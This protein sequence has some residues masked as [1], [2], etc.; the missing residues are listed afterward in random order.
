MVIL[1]VLV[2]IEISKKSGIFAIVDDAPCWIVLQ[3]VNHEKARSRRLDGLKKLHLPGKAENLLPV[4]TNE[5]FGGR[6]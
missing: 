5:V 3:V 2:Y 6:H 1:Y 4:T